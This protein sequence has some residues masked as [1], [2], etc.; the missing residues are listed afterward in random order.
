MWKKSGYEKNHARLGTQT[1]PSCNVL[2]TRHV[3]PAGRQVPSPTQGQLNLEELWQGG[4]LGEGDSTLS[5]HLPPYRTDLAEVERN[6]PTR[7]V[8]Q[9]CSHALEVA[10]QRPDQVVLRDILL[11][12]FQRS[13]V[14]RCRYSTCA[15]KGARLKLRLQFFPSQCSTPWLKN[16]TLSRYILKTLNSSRQSLCI[17]NFTLCLSWQRN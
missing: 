14:P 17:V 12:S 7:D 4:V 15:G 10:Y 5:G 9:T 6:T 8:T 13:S 11:S 3:H 2:L 16:R 1:W